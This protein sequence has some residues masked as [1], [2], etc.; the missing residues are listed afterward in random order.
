MKRIEY[1]ICP[2]CECE[3][4]PARAGLGRFLCPFC[5]C[6]Y[7][8]NF[9]HWFVGLSL[10]G[11]AGFGMWKVLGKALSAGFTLPW[12]AQLLGTVIGAFLL[13]WPVIGLIPRYTVARPGI[14]PKAPPP[15]ANRDIR[16]RG[17]KRLSRT[18]PLPGTTQTRFEAANPLRP[19]K[20]L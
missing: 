5:N 1:P 17:S 16:P 7:R 11:A 19:T 6:E 15:V 4:K 3:V 10:L 9:W 14:P 18:Q 13:T 20:E 2:C 8:H 12:Q